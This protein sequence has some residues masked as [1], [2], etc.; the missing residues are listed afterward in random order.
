M[1]FIDPLSKMAATFLNPEPRPGDGAWLLQQSSKKRK[2]RKKVQSFLRQSPARVLDEV[3]G[4]EGGPGRNHHETFLRPSLLDPRHEVKVED[5]GPGK[6]ERETFLRAYGNGKERA[7]SPQ[8]PDPSVPRTIANETLLSRDG[9]ERV[10]SL[11]LGTATHL[12]QLIHPAYA[13]ERKSD[14]TDNEEMAA[15]TRAK[16]VAPHLRKKNE[17]SKPTHDAPQPVKNEDPQP[18]TE[19]QP[20]R[21]GECKSNSKPPAVKVVNTDIRQK[22][23]EEHGVNVS[24][25]R[26][27][28]PALVTY[29]SSNEE[30]RGPLN[31]G[32][33]PHPTGP[34][35]GESKRGNTSARRAR[36]GRG[37][38]APQESTWPQATYPSS[39]EEHKGLPNGAPKPLPTGSSTGESKR[40]KPS[41]RGRGTRGG[42]LPRE[43]RW[44]THA[45]T[46]PDPK[47]WEINWDSDERSFSSVD[48]VCA[49][50]GFGDDKKKKKQVED[51]ID[52]DTGFKLTDW[53]GNWAPA[54]V[55]WD[56]RPAFRD[57][58]SAQKIE[59]W[60]DGI[61]EEMRRGTGAKSWAIPTED[62]TVNGTTYCFAPDSEKTDLRIMGE[63]APR[64]WLPV[65][66]G[67]NSAHTVPQAPQ[68]FWNE[69]VKSNMPI[70]YDEN[71]LVGAKPWWETYQTAGGDFLKHYEPPTIRGID[72][73]ENEGERIAREHDR[74]SNYHTENRKKAEKAKKEAQRERRKKAQEKARKISQVSIDRQNQD[75]I[76]PGIEL[77]VR[78]ARPEDMSRIREI[79]NYYVDFS[80]CTPETMRRT[81]ADMQQRLDDVHH[82][83]LPFLVA[84][85]RGG[86]VPAR[87]KKAKG[88]DLI[89]PDKVVGFAMA[90]DY[91][92]MQGMYRFT[93][94]IEVYTDKEYYMKGVAKCL[95]DKLMAL[96]DP[97]YIEKGGYEVVG[98]DLDGSGAKRRI[99][100][101]M[102]NL[103]YDK[104]KPERL[105][106][107]EKWLH[108]WLGF[109]K[110]GD[111]QGIGL[112][113]GKR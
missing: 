3:I 103:P 58:Q 34:S 51:G 47:R 100:N 95:L 79:Y 7:T 80:V 41:S 88:E 92:D 96:L 68:T 10:C 64:Y 11:E 105:E 35:T 84:C 91:N 55:D 24:D 28:K 81:K 59:H 12:Q 63:P 20:V 31:G 46:K 22:L 65:V 52:P 4:D 13:F 83:L 94:E 82:N 109:D 17:E 9:Q 36:G 86:K 113:E 76:K 53:S 98:E 44:P 69:L 8:P 54:P 48:S 62:V 5:Q 40:G 106:W 30:H 6:S 18:A 66:F 37:G 77:Y 67:H 45:E 71:D 42:R 23:A 56:A 75:K 74:G 72:P 32:F 99:S 89:L 38:R 25:P 15:V 2:T 93:A 39:N 70:P 21:N 102:V 112:K 27:A 61:E 29:P 1:H 101:I 110:V 26:P 49:N 111:L 50:A 43:S 107:M 14:S 87:R 73:D 60:M 108:T 104:D 19:T 57:G 78:S 85:E 16:C 97:Q 33:Q 90:D